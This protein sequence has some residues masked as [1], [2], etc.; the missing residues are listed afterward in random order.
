MDKDYIEF[1][2]WL[3]SNK[4]AKYICCQ[5][6]RYNG[7]IYNTDQLFEIFKTEYHGN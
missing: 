3:F 5:T 7:S 2:E 6:W 1:I 4:K